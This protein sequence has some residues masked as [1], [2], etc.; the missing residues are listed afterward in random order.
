MQDCNN[1]LVAETGLLCKC[2]FTVRVGRAVHFVNEFSQNATKPRA[3]TAWLM[4]VGDIT[5]AKLS[6]MSSAVMS[7]EP[8]SSIPMTMGSKSIVDEAMSF[9]K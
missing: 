7:R 6:Q 9:S 5:N 2:G 8:H 1:R 4:Q 3:V